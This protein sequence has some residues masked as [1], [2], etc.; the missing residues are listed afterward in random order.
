MAT[1]YFNAAVD[2]DW[3]ELG[4]WWQ[5]EACTVAAA[6]LPTSADNVVSLAVIGANSGTE[7]T[8][9]NLTLNDDLAIPV[10]VTG[11][12]TISSGYISA[13]ITT[14]LAVFNGGLLDY[15]G[16][17]T[18]DAEFNGGAGSRGY[19][20]GNA[21]FNDTSYNYDGGTVSGNATFN[22]DSENQAYATVYGLATFNG[23]SE[24]KVFATCNTSAI[25]NDNSYNWGYVGADA[26]FND[27]SAADETCAGTL[28]ANDYTYIYY[29]GV[30]ASPTSATFN[31]YSTHGNGFVSYNN[32]LNDNA[33]VNNQGYVSG[34]TFTFNDNSYGGVQSATYVNINGNPIVTT[35]IAHQS[36]PFSVN[37]VRRSGING[38]S[39]LGVL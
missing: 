37:F 12:A 25:F 16:N 30:T 23:T 4:N 22:D 11:A 8:V 18:G 10:T 27:Y 7:P 29:S 13:T 31:D 38:S 19:V 34:D 15:S 1:L 9:A 35:G 21:V 36:G 39:V 14:P 6:S 28:T 32:T 2:T 3:A 24:N 5:D 20:A 17:I 33:F 26:T